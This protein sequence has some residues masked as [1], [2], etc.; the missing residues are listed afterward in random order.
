M[1]TNIHHNIP[2]ALFGEDIPENKVSIDTKLHDKIHGTQNLSQNRLRRTRMEVNSILV[3]NDRFWDIRREIWGE[4]F[5]PANTLVNTQKNKLKELTELYIG[6]C[7]SEE[8]ASIWSFEDML[9]E[10]VYVQ[11]WYFRKKVASF[12]QFEK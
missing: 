3:P 9:D 7:W 2:I 4:Y 5:E 10:L 11:R 8:K 1:K 6:K 12:L